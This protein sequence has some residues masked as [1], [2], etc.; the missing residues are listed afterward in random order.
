MI[1]NTEERKARKQRIPLYRKYILI[2]WFGMISLWVILSIILIFA[3][4]TMWSS[5]N[6]EYFLTTNNLPVIV[7]VYGNISGLIFLIVYF[8]YFRR[9]PDFDKWKKRKKGLRLKKNR[10]EFYR[11]YPK[12][13]A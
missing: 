13:G 4:Q 3:I 12:D 5:F 8:F 6:F 7:I 10:K 9:F 11:L 2:K 1:N